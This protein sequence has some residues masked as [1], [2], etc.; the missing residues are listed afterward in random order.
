MAEPE[1]QQGP[2]RDGP[3]DQPEAASPATGERRAR[4]DRPRGSR[5]RRPPRPGPRRCRGRGVPRGCARRPRADP[6]ADRSAARGR[7]RPGARRRGGARFRIAV[8]PA[9]RAARA[10]AERLLGA[11]SARHATRRSRAPRCPGDHPVRW[12]DVRVRRRRPQGGRLDLERPA[13]RA[14]HLLR[15]SADGARAGWRCPARDAP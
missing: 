8:Q 1:E 6:G 4:Q 9:D 11:P 12:T 10:R 5:Q 7:H 2:G 3:G 15:R 14:R 13:A